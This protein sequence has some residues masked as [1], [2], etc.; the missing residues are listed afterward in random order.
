MEY[1]TLGRTGLK[2][3]AISLGTEYLNG[4]PRETV[5]AVVAEALADVV[6]TADLR[7]RVG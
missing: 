2:V 7:Q 4:Q 1:R 3:S 6:E 5:G